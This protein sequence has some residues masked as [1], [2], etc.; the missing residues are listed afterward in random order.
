MGVYVCLSNLSYVDSISHMLCLF[1]FRAS[2]DEELLIYRAKRFIYDVWDTVNFSWVVSFLVANLHSSLTVSMRCVRINIFLCG[3]VNSCR[4]YRAWTYFILV[5]ALYS[6]FFTPLEF[7]FFRGLPENLLLLDV[8]GQIAFLVDI[9]FQFFIAYKDDQT[10]KMVHKRSL[11]A[12]RLVCLLLVFIICE[13]AWICICLNG[14]HLYHPHGSYLKSSFLIDLLGC[15]P[16]DAIYK[17]R[18]VHNYL[19][20]LMAFYF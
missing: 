17:V 1:F 19:D 13:V 3:L 4:L 9:V 5:W 12:L 8:A 15:M 20:W 18:I 2:S 11:I 16:W 6:S 7:G 14:K 10:Y